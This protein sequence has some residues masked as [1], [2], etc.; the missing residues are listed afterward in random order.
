MI[1]DFIHSISKQWPSHSL[2]QVATLV[3]ARATQLHLI[4]KKKY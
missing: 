3:R 2:S 4:K 1:V